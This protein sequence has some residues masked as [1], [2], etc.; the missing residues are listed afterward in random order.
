ML[1]RKSKQE[2]KEKQKR[3]SLILLTFLLILSSGIFP[4]YTEAEIISRGSNLKQVG[5]INDSN[6][7]PLWYKDSNDV[8][9]ELCL[10][11]RYLLCTCTRRFQCKFANYFPRQLPWR[12]ILSV[13]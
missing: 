3:I 9:L 12:S 4:G 6:G 1:I 10:D 13:S 11:P 7:F 8:K 2:K 5:P